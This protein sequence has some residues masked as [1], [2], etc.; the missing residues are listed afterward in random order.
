[1]DAADTGY[2]FSDAIKV[3][4]NTW[5]KLP[6]NIGKAINDAPALSAIT[7]QI[8]DAFRS[9]VSNL[10]YTAVTK[11]FNNALVSGIN[12]IN[13]FSP[14]IN[15]LKALLIGAWNDPENAWKLSTMSMLGVVRSFLGSVT[16]E[17]LTFAAKVGT[18]INIIPQTINTAG[19]ALSTAAGSIVLG[20]RSA[21]E[22]IIN[23]VGSG[24]TTVLKF[25]RDTHQ[26]FVLM[27]SGSP[28]I[29]KALGIDPENLA[30]EQQALD[31]FTAQT[32]GAVKGIKSQMAK[33]SSDM[34]A[35][36][37]ARAKESSTWFKD[38]IDVAS[39]ERK[40]Q[41]IQS[42]I[43]KITY[44]GIAESFNG[45]AA[46][47]NASDWFSR[48]TKEQQDVVAGPTVAQSWESSDVQSK[49]WFKRLTPQQ[50]AVILGNDGGGGGGSGGGS[51][52]GGNRSLDIN[53]PDN[54]NV[55]EALVAAIIAEL[56]RQAELEGT[57][58]QA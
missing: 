1:M 37:A 26:S 21:M 24:V 7:K 43:D 50:Q 45:A 53:I 22:G 6:L 16:S 32:I 2:N 34:A 52:S 9:F 19:S 39:I 57:M 46:N 14:Q 17:A 20:V 58:I 25:V 42:S 48:L 13:S 35:N 11:F 5:E 27:A 56:R 15:S 10:D 51:G 4:N 31:S 29:M 40:N 30:K 12:F 44:K 47:V 33:E 55:L 41:E 49:E 38:W 18:V 36:Y 8:S 28:M 3:I 23:L 54:P